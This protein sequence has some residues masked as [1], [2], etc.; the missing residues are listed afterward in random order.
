M[1][2]TLS[3]TACVENCCKSLVITDTTGVATA[4]GDGS[5]DWNDTVEYDDVDEALITITY[6]SGTEEEIDVTDEF[7]AAITGTFAFNDIIGTYPDG[8][9]EITYQITDTSSNVYSKTITTY[10]Y[11]NSQCCIDHMWAQIPSKMC[12]GCD[13]EDYLENTL[14]AEALLTG[15][16]S[17][18]N[19]I[20]ETAMDD[21]LDL[22]SDYC[23]FNNC[24]ECI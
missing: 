20:N 16:I 24:S 15:L 17:S 21:L 3:F 2:L 19:C 18:I 1:A 22:I 9:Y 23:D 7:T 12:N 13:Y 5:G 11:C 4:P 14:N 6:P 10:N 8:Q